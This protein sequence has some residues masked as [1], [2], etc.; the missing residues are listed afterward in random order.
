MNRS[1]IL[2]VLLGSLL[3]GCGRSEPVTP[4]SWS[5]SIPL[6]MERATE[7]QVLFVYFHADWCH[8]CEQMNEY[9][10]PTAEV[11]RALS[12]FVPVKID[13]DEQPAVAETFLADVTPAYVLVDREGT[14]RAR[15]IGLMT[16]E[17]LADFLKDSA[18]L[19][20]AEQVDEGAETS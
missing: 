9:I 16:A 15:A 12:P 5:G 4:I 17:E 7:N 2:L 13:I 8:V 18:R 20:E 1:C 10:F 19:L 6:G 14:V 3:A 11:S